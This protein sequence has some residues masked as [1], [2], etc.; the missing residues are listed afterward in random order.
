[1]APEIASDF[2]KEKLISAAPIHRWYGRRGASTSLLSLL[3]TANPELAVD[4]EVLHKATDNPSAYESEIVR[5]LRVL[6]LCCGSGSLSEAAARLGAAVTAIDSH[7]IPVLMTRVAL[8]YSQS[9]SKASKA[10]TGCSTGKT[11]A[12]LGEEIAYWLNELI[13]EARR[14]A[15]GSWWPDV[16]IVHCEKMYQCPNC[17]SQSRWPSRHTPDSSLFRWADAESA[18]CMS[19]GDVLR[20]DCLGPGKIVPVSISMLNN[21]KANEET[22]ADCINASF[23]NALADS[24]DHIWFEATRPKASLRLRDFCSPR[25][26]ELLVALRYAYRAIRDRLSDLNYDPLRAKALLESMALCLSNTLEYLSHSCT[27]NSR[28]KRAMGL[29]TM[30]WRAGSSYAEIGGSRLEA[31]IRK[32][33]RRISDLLS[34]QSIK[35]SVCVAS[36]DMQD[37]GCLPDKYDLV[38]WDPP[39]Y[40][41]IDYAGIARPWSLYLRSLLGDIDTL[42]PWDNALNPVKSGISE[43]IY[44]DNIIGGTLKA[45]STILVPGGK[46]GMLWMRIESSEQEA[47]AH[48]IGE[49]TKHGLELVQSYSLID[50][51]SLLHK[52]PRNLVNLCV[53]FIFSRTVGPAIP[54]DASSILVGALEGRSMMY[55]GIVE[56]LT[57]SLEHDEIEFLIHDGYKGTQL[58]RLA[59]TVMSSPNPIDL[60]RD[61]NR[62]DLKRYALSRGISDS[63]IGGKSADQM[64]RIVLQ[65]LGW[66][67]PSNPSFTIESALEELSSIEAEI[68]LVNSEQEIRGLATKAFDRLER[69][70]RFSVIAWA[71]L[72]SPNDWKE[73][74]RRTTTKESRYTFG[75]WHRC[76]VEIPSK[77]ASQSEVAGRINGLLNKNKVQK[78][79][80]PLLKLRNTICHHD[81]S[82]ENWT[83]IK[84]ELLEKLSACI[85][86]LRRAYSEKALPM[87]LMPERETRDIYGRITLRLISGN[88]LPYEFLMTHQA[89]LSQPVVVIACGSNPREVEPWLMNAAELCDLASV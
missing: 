49:A 23:P 87:I 13:E 61:V 14:K 58:Q 55:E 16:D 2:T 83:D 40:D 78:S 64:R 11:W 73:P 71:H 1:M 28:L 17:L 63:D 37:I 42:L 4:K 54:A 35:N 31:I 70:L 68:R 67:I 69:I 26:A 34:S 53:L 8:Q 38:L 75:D 66:S 29:Q 19:C 88:G 86:A 82:K 60:L 47:F 9:F 81:Q 79:I 80:E 32:N 27:Y 24:L 5:N 62:R 44:R 48:L 25:Q 43:E 46:L 56:I 50:S 41:N 59:E 52:T 76:L 20:K 10:N 65:L 74:V 30:R 84:V 89:D 18:R 21:K 22:I 6:D 39:Y 51:K 77:Y 7:P 33:G 12:G 15:I 57:E 45:I 36:M 72:I 3:L 85:D